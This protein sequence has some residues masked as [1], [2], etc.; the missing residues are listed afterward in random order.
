M[1]PHKTGKKQESLA[2]ESNPNMDILSDTTAWI[3]DMLKSWKHVYDILEHEILLFLNDSI[4]EDDEILSAKLRLAAQSELHRIT[5]QPK[6]MPCSDMISWA[7]DHVDIPSRSVSNHHKTHVGSFRSEYWRVIYK[8]SFE[9]KYTYNSS[10]LLDFEQRECTCCGRIGHDI[11]K[12]WW[13]NPTKFKTDTHGIYSTT[14]LDAH[15]LCISMMLRQLFWKK[16]PTHF[17]VEWVSIIHEVVEGYTL[18]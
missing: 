9:P 4:E 5:A 13:G 3:R 17:T 18:N 10:F 11:V 1:L 12:N 7:L 16:N 15:F 14:Y 8:L 6:I 2:E